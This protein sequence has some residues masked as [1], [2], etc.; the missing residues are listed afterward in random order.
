MYIII[1][2]LHFVHCTYILCALFGEILGYNFANFKY[3]YVDT[4]VYVF[5]HVTV[6]NQKKVF[7]MMYNAMIQTPLTP[8]H[9]TVIPLRNI[10]VY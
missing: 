4:Y 5:L 10:F 9:L 8:L 6:S 3:M 1:Y 2:K 7:D